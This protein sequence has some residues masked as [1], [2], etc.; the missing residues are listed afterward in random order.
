MGILWLYIAFCL[1]FWAGVGA[2]Y[3]YLRI[4]RP[5]VHDYSDWL[6]HDEPIPIVV[7]RARKAKP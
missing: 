3:L 6:N 1:G 5:R 7:R 2:T 4:T